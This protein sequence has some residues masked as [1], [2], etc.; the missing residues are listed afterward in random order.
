ML[1]AGSAVGRALG[2]SSLPNGA[3]AEHQALAL[4]HPD[5]QACFAQ[6]LR[7]TRAAPGQSARLLVR[8]H[9][10]GGEPVSVIA[11]IAL[12]ASGLVHVEIQLDDAA[13]ARRAEAQIRQVVEG[14]QQAA[15]VTVGNRIAYSN[16]AL[17]RMLGFRSL[18][19]LRASGSS[20]DHVHPDDRPTVVQRALAR[21]AQQ[22]PSD[23]YDFRLCRADGTV[24]WVAA[25]ISQV[26]WNGE[27]ASLAWLID[28]TDRK[29]AEDALLRSEK[30][31]G[32]VFKASP[33]M[34]TLSRLDS[35]RFIDVNESFLRT[36]GFAREEVIGRS[37]RELGIFRDAEIYRRLGRG[38]NREEVA[39][40]RTCD[41]QDRSFALSSQILRFADQDM[42]LTVAI[43]V[44][45][46][47]RNEAA[48]R[49]SQQAAE[50]ANRTKSE[51]LANM[52]HELR[53]PL[54]AIIG[55]S[56]VI[57]GEMFGPVGEPRYAEYARDI[58]NSGQHLLRIIND[59][60]DLSKLE[61]GKQ[62]LHESEIG[63]AELI[64]TSVRLVQPRATAAGLTLAVN[65]PA[66]LPALRADAR[67]LK[68]ILINLL[69]NAVKFT[70]NG[71][72]TVCARLQDGALSI[73]VADTGIGMSDRE[74]ELA[75]APFGQVDSGLSRKHEGTGLGL[76]LARA[77]AELHGGRLEVLSTPGTG[78]TMTVRFP[79]QRTLAR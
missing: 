19:E 5:D 25:Y 39:E 61:S 14:A 44:T 13:A 1:S 58:L 41:G 6:I 27:L 31:F 64:G 78:T 37:E 42:L 34:L 47:R 28:I 68:Q 49:R 56:E 40:V 3:I 52:S 9:R 15:V 35:G 21:A 65:V 30:L 67:L 4:L 71:G 38:A 43:D 22:D 70:P 69:S 74:I 45:D 20:F 26:T 7:W 57:V 23:S 18:E 73:A 36:L 46:R 75:L 62:Q 79:A 8:L 29:R 59:L 77:F 16:H 54:N 51:F 55:F 11:H 72:V 33:A 66:G 32:T 2:A 24:I 12:G 76:P 48:L 63:L 60:L 17:A 53:T 10:T 50:L